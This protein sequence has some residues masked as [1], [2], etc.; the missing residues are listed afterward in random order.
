[1][2]CVTTTSNGSIMLRVYVQ[3]KASRTGFG[4]IHD[5]MLKLSITAA[6]VDGKANK[7]VISFLAK[8]FHIS[9]KEVTIVAGEKSRRKKCIIARL[10][11]GEILKLLK[12]KNPL[13]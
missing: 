9:K 13:L 6:P 7:A 11:E 1:M 4:G 10:S 3:P 2:S 5:D 12:E 8:F